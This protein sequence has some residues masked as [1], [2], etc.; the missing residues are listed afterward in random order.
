MYNSSGVELR[1]TGAGPF[2]RDGLFENKTTGRPSEAYL[3]IVFG[4][5]PTVLEGGVSVLARGSRLSQ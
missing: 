1:L 5:F 4:P 2:F 3:Y